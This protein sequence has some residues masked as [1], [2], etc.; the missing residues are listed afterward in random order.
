MRIVNLTPHTINVMKGDE[1][2]AQL[3][4]EGIARAEQKNIHVGCVEINDERIP[5]LFSVFGVVVDL[6]EPEPDTYYVVSLA[7]AQAA[8]R[9]N[10]TTRDLLITSKPVRN[11]AGQIIGCEAFSQI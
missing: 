4:S 7:T 3:P 11:D 10:R 8:Q 2:V 5:I 9:S 1:V 6:P